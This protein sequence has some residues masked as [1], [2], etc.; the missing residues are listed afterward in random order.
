MCVYVDVCCNYVHSGCQQNLLP[1]RED[2]ATCTSVEAHSFKLA[3]LEWIKA[4]L[5]DRTQYM[6]INGIH[7]PQRSAVPQGSD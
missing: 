6:Y 3:L 1:C 5:N 7:V 2:K 4:F